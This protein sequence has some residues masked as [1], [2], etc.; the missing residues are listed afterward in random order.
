MSRYESDSEWVTL[1]GGV[2]GITRW[3]SL[4]EALEGFLTDDAEAG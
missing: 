3:V 1:D 4:D 2:A